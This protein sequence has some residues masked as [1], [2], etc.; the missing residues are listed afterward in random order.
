MLVEPALAVCH[1]SGYETCRA[2]FDVLKIL[3][4]M[5]TTTAFLLVLLMSVS[6][7]VA[8]SHPHAFKRLVTKRR[9][10]GSMAI[11]VAYSAAFSALKASG[12]V[13]PATMFAVEVCFHATFIPFLLG[14][15]YVVVLVAL[16][17]HTRRRFSV[18]FRRSVVSISDSRLSIASVDIPLIGIVERHFIRMNLLLIVTLLVCTLPSVVVLHIILSQSRLHRMT[19]EHQLNLAIAEYIS[20]DVLFLKFLLDPLIFAW[21][22]R[23]L[24]L[25][26]TFWRITRNWDRL[27][28][29]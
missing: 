10:V 2:E 14:T 23:R 8:I 19:L 12:L 28:E 29:D 24:W 6:Q 22:T 27:E 26:A 5:V 16:R 9:V 25:G 20:E 17:R 4:G 1:I 21:S 3:P 7:Y 15:F 13:H 11:A 18:L